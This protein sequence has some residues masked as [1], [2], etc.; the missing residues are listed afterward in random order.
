MIFIFEGCEGSGKSTIIKEIKRKLIEVGID[1]DKILITKEPGSNIPVNKNIRK[2]IFDTDMDPVTEAYLYAA[3]RSEH[4][5][6]ILEPNVYSDNIVLC[7]RSIYSSIVYQGIARG[8]GESTIY[9]INKYAM[10]PLYK[11]NKFDDVN[12][13]FIDVKPEV[14]LD[15]VNSSESRE[16]NRL[17]KESLSFHNKVYGGYQEL[18][19]MRP[20]RFKVVENENI[21]DAVD[22]AVKII[23]SK[24]KIHHMFSNENK[25]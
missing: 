7:D 25:E 5:R 17:D 6:N 9:E 21:V 13:F 12:V 15:R 20:F 1:E 23:L 11:N 19:K 24:N 10:E 22:A 16:V 2:T 18:I 4:V 14:G 8:L 3:D